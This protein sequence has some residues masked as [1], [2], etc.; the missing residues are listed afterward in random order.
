MSSDT[1][2]TR[3]DRET[4]LPQAMV[5]A[6][7]L[8]SKLKTHTARHCQSLS[9]DDCASLLAFDS[10]GM[11]FHCPLDDAQFESAVL[12]FTAAAVSARFGNDRPSA[13]DV[14][15][16]APVDAPARARPA[17]LGPRAHTVS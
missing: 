8:R 13:G 15:D 2:L 3:G 7:S 11:S 16:A 9:W 5:A 10:N 4:H 14:P 1:L 6:S 17:R 12:R